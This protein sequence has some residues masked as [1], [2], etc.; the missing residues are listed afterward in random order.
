[1]IKNYFILAIIFVCGFSAACNQ[2]G[3]PVEYSKACTA[4]NDKKYIEVS[5][6]LSPRRS[7]YCSN[8]GG[9]PVRCGVNLLEAPDSQKDNL[10]A[11]IERG[12][13][14]SNIEEI[15]G[16]FKKEDIKIHDQSGGIINLADKVKVTGKLNKI[17]D[18]D[19]C[20]LTVSKI[21]K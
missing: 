10:S 11:D 13:G 3:V 1:M 19:Q 2:T 5:G 16:S 15:K 12:N 20:Y 6:F 8:T 21:E 14:A 7:V 4:E 18:A 9:G 17:P